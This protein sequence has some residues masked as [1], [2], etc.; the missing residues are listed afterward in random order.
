MHPRDHV[1]G[2]GRILRGIDRMSEPT[3][4]EPRVFR[5]DRVNMLTHE[6]L[7]RRCKAI[8]DRFGTR[9]QL[10]RKRNFIGSSLD[11]LDDIDYLESERR[12]S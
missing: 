10:E 6:Y 5:I 7:R 2:D 3:K 8:E 11:D 1:G 4:K 12:A 9:E